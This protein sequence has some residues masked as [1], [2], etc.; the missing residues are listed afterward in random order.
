M[1]KNVKPDIDR[2]QE[3]RNYFQ[4]TVADA[5]GKSIRKTL[6]FS[7][8]PLI[9]VAHMVNRQNAVAQPDLKHGPVSIGMVEFKLLVNLARYP[10]SN[11]ANNSEL[12][13]IDKAALSR[14]LSKMKSLDLV[15]ESS[16]EGDERRKFYHLT[17]RGYELHDH[18][19]KQNIE[20]HLEVLKGLSTDEI[21]QFNATLQ[22]I[23]GNL[24]NLTN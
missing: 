22:L 5:D 21:D 16:K 1:K 9:M 18:H 6:S 11:L 3:L 10:G 17:D 23:L 15:T 13:G 20:L 2:D 4:A 24:E 14:S 19:I 8:S 12:I 7:R